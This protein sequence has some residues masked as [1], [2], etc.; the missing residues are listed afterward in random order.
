MGADEI[1]AV[2][3]GYTRQSHRLQTFDDECSRSIPLYHWQ[4]GG[5]EIL[6]V[7]ETKFTHLLRVKP[8]GR[9]KGHSRACDKTNIEIQAYDQLVRPPIIKNAG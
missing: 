7:K 4:N 1:T 2:P 3:D 9:R 8:T 5:S 6:P